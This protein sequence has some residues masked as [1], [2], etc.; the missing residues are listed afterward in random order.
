MK[1]EID[2]CELMF[3]AESI[4]PPRPIARSMSFDDL[5]EK[6]Y[7]KMTDSQREQMFKHVCSQYGFDLDN[8]KCV[9]FHHRFNPENQYK[10]RT[11][12]FGVF[13]CYLHNG[14][15]HI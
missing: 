15:Y 6:H 5:S 2:F 3:L 7:H 13:D 4:I 11:S 12:K 8:E 1:F 10:V 14:Q 9:H